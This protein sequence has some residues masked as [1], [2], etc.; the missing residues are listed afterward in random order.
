M[1]QRASQFLKK[2]QASKAG[3]RHCKVASRRF[4]NA[5]YFYDKALKS[6]PNVDVQ[7]FSYKGIK[8]RTKEETIVML[9]DCVGAAC[10]ANQEVD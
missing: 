4:Y 6:D 5:E 3:D 9:A 1:S 2:E 8:P 7:K 10:R